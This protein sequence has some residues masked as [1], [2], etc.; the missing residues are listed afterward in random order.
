MDY[1]DILKRTAARY[2]VPEPEPC[3]CG[4]KYY[5]GDDGSGFCWRPSCNCKG[6]KRSM[7]FGYDGDEMCRCPNCNKTQ[8]N[9]NNKT[10]NF[11]LTSPKH[12]TT[13]QSPL[14][15]SLQMNILFYE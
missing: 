5:V 14:I 2:G 10:C 8:D 9:H 3:K 6:N 12:W 15:I 1:V 11:R 13:T 7:R 4:A